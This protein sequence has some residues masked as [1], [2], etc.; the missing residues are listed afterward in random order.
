MRVISFANQKGGT[1]KTT[2]AVNL[3]AIL[4]REGKKTLV[5]DLDPQSNATM[6]LI[7]PMEVESKRSIGPLLLGDAKLEDVIYECKYVK[8]LHLI[9]ATLELSLT[10]LELTRTSS[11]TAGI[12]LE[13]RLR[14]TEYDFVICDCP[15]NFGILTTNGLY[16]SSHMIVP[17]EPETF[18]V[19]GL[20]L[21]MTHIVPR[22]GKLINDKL[23]LLGIL[24]VRV[25]PIR[26]LTAN[27]RYEV[28]SRYGDLL[29]DT[30]IPID[31]RLPESQRSHSPIV[32]YARTSRAAEAYEALTKEVLDRL[33]EE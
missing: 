30:E 31:V 26:T 24:L 1:G 8:N 3:A 12:Q 7:D 21:L 9:P 22:I 28:R 4:A 15:P 10:E 16:A 32:I 33:G 2:T 20:R 27:V 13:K 14:N 25:N 6:A 18:A 29:F 5:V 11:G 17:M 23:K 19:Y